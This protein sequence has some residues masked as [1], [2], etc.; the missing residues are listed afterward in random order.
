MLLCRRLKRI[1]KRYYYQKM[2]RINKS[3]ASGEMIYWADTVA[4]PRFWFS[5][6]LSII[7]TVLIAL[8][9]GIEYGSTGAYALGI[10]SFLV[11][12]WCISKFIDWVCP[13]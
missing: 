6:C 12:W 9:Y 10:F 11:I 5:I 13:L 1:C 4:T 7:V 8:E 2:A 3:W